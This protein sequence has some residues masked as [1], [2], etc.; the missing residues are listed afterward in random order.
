MFSYTNNKNMYIALA[1]IVI[2]SVAYVAINEALDFK[3][4]KDKED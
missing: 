3:T 4:K 2:L 1:S